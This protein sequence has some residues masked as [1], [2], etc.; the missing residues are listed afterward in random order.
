[1]K[2]ALTLAVIGVASL[3][4]TACTSPAGGSMFDYR[5]ATSVPQG[6]ARLII[7]R[8]K[9]TFIVQASQGIEPVVQFDGVYYGNVLDGAFMVVD[10]PPGPHSLT[11]GHPGDQTSLLYGAVA[12][13]VTY[14]KIWDK[15]RMGGPLA[16]THANVNS[17]TS[18]GRTWGAVQVGEPAALTQ[19]STLRDPS[20]EPTEQDSG[21]NAAQQ[22]PAR[23]EESNRAS[24]MFL[25]A[26]AS[27][28]TRTPAATDLN[29]MTGV[30][31][32]E[33]QQ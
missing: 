21:G 12:G 5:A 11:I 1:M 19:L 27:S 14:L 22:A 26:L 31:N 4:A 24:M 33:A 18:E 2:R 10:A 23:A 16:A 3:F 30:L 25:C 6:T 28:L 9:A 29:C 20:S 13:K 8:T 17:G 15:T 32:S 7:F